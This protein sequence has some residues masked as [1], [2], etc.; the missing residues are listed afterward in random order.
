MRNGLKL[1]TACGFLIL[2][3]CSSV[4]NQHASLLQ[5]TLEQQQLTLPNL[6][7]EIFTLLPVPTEADIFSLTEAQKKHFLDY[8]HDPRNRKIAGH[9]RLFNY[10]DAFV[11][12]FGFRGATLKASEALSL[13]NGNCLTLAIVTKALADIVNLEVSYQVV[14]AAPVYALNSSLMTLSSHV[15]TYIYD[16]NYQPSLGMMVLRRRSIIID[17]FPSESDI[18]G[19]HI[20]HN[21]FMAM[22]YQNIAAEALLDGQLDYAYSTLQQG[23]TF[24]PF[25][26]E[27]LNSLAVTFNRAGDAKQAETL[28]KFMLDNDFA[29]GNVISNYVALLQLQGRDSEVAALA[30]KVA[31][32]NDDNPYR[33]IDMADEAFAAAQ[34]TL[35]FKYYQKANETAPYLHEGQF[36]LAKS[37]Y[38]LGRLNSA[39]KALNKAIELSYKSHDRRLYEAKLHT[40]LMEKN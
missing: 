23:L 32:I 30:Q 37:H 7:T 14:H 21:D 40:L 19:E 36:G 35:A 13:K 8:Y 27:T 9:L 2:G 11:H 20:S 25:N 1:I 10:F 26:A 6:N 39:E 16:P 33:W 5:E 31:E 38:Q 18:R 24:N 15:R 4:A 12:Q 3:G 22:Y 34:Y 17:Y 28:Y 29:S